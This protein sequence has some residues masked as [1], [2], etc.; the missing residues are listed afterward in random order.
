M[1]LRH[2]FTFTPADLLSKTDTSNE[3]DDGERTFL[4][5]TLQDGYYKI[6]K[7]IL[8][9]KHDLM[10]EANMRFSA[11]T[12]IAQRVISVFRRID[13][14]VDEPIIVGGVN[15]DAIPQEGVQDFV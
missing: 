2:T 14:L 1:T 13:E 5:G 3:S 15:P 11:G 10:L 7:D 9:L 12:F 8:G 6:N 4:L